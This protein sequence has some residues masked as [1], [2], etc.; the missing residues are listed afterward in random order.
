M[1]TSGAFVPCIMQVSRLVTFRARK[2]PYHLARSVTTTCWCK[3]SLHW[4]TVCMLPSRHLKRSGIEPNTTHCHLTHPLCL[5]SG[6]SR[7][8]SGTSGWR[9]CRRR[10]S[11][12]R[13]VDFPLELYL[14]RSRFWYGLTLL[15]PSRVA[16]L[17]L[18]GYMTNNGWGRDIV[19]L[20]QCA[21]SAK[22]GVSVTRSTL[23]S[24]T[25]SNAL[26]SLTR[27]YSTLFEH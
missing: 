19:V 6:L 8:D 3:D 15:I 24:S 7:I 11:R 10:Y 9:R 12:N 26:P 21:C 18:S 2:G 14:I 20:R 16:T 25:R 5:R 17:F 27:V 23:V 1:S 22:P 4:L 13:F